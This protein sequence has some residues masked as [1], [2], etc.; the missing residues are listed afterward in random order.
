MANKLFKTAEGNTF[1]CVL[2]LSEDGEELAILTGDNWPA[3]GDKIFDNIGI[4]RGG[5]LDGD[6]A[7]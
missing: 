6:E 5:N 4:Y 7:W 3:E 1:K 2:V